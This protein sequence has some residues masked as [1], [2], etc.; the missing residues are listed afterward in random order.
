MLTNH[1]IR[2]HGVTVRTELASDLPVV[3]GDSVQLRQAI[4]NLIMNAVEATGAVLEGLHELVAS[5]R[6]YPPDSVVVAVRDNGMG[7]EPANLDRIFQPFF[8]TKASGMGMGLTVTKS[9]IEA[10]GGK[11]WATPNAGQGMT[12]Q[13]SVPASSAA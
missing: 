1:E 13:F 11:L 10:H 4:L 6:L 5:S 12:F 7:I 3:R 8:T 9:A 2:K